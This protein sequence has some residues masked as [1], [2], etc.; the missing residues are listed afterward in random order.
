MIFS[1]F[2]AFTNSK[3]KG[4]VIDYEL[5]IQ[6]V[7]INGNGGRR[8]KSHDAEQMNQPEMSSSSP[9]QRGKKMLTFNHSNRAKFNTFLGY[10]CLMT[11]LYHLTYILVG[12][13]R[14][15]E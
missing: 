13:W 15:E 11:C 10:A 8:K 6:K 12:L 2:R 4:S 3:S 9:A 7:N 1:I 5:G 14:L